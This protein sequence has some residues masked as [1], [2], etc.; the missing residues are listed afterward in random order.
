MP[1]TFGTYN[2]AYSG[3]YVSHAGLTTTTNNLSNASTPGASRVRVALKDT[4]T[5]LPDN[6]SLTSGSKVA[7]I[8]RA[9]DIL[10]D[11]TYRVQNADSSYW[12]VKNG[13]LEYM[14]E[15]LN[16]YAAD[17]GTSRDGLQNLLNNFFTSWDALSTDTTSLSARQQVV[18]SAT[19]L[20]KG[21]TEIHDQL[22]Q[23]QDD[24]VTGVA[25]G[26]DSLNFLAEQVAGLN[27]Q[28]SVAEVNGEEASYL[29]D[30][31]DVLL[32]QMS[33][34]AN[35]GV[36]ETS[37]GLAVTINGAAMV[38]GNNARKLVTTGTGTANDPI[39]I[40]WKDSGKGVDISSG[41]IAAYREDADQAAY[42]PIDTA[43]LPYNFSASSA[44]SITNMMQAL[45]DM[46]TTVAT[47]TNSL[48]TSISGGVNFFTV[49]DA[50]QPLSIANIQV[51]PSVADDARL[52]VTGAKD[53]D[54]SIS[55]AVYDL[56][57]ENILKFDG[58]DMGLGDFY[59]SFVSWIG[60]V[61]NNAASSYETQTALVSQVDN[62]RQSISNISLDEEMS[63]LVIYQNAY[64]ANAR[65]LSTIDGLI[66]DLIRDLG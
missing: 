57:D 12:S 35:I 53:G 64:N 62:Q 58:L 2:V 26:V 42:G 16:E 33:A 23:L 28:I 19:S 36:T 39:K 34:L 27:Q 17:D 8:T 47:K 54:N 43:S 51:N 60:T 63:N 20:V 46:L 21:L 1:S 24:A 22:Q 56:L 3:M 41:S 49:A 44:S 61:G 4:T 31:R 5:T 32:D 25:D 30:Q 18:D 50:N 52:I 9:R 40:T 55:S 14:Q 10:L 45:N 6:T 15:L 66:G 29:R 65:V 7:S 11:A 48:Q 37:N 13:N 59:Q 38:Y